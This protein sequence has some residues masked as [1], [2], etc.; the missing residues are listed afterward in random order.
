L[1]KP[2]EVASDIRPAT[3]AFSAVS[4]TLAVGNQTKLMINENTPA[5]G[6]FEQAKTCLNAIVRARSLGFLDRYSTRDVQAAVDYL[7]RTLAREDLATQSTAGLFSSTG[8]PERVIALAAL[9][10]AY[11]DDSPVAQANRTAAEDVFRFI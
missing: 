7:D 6:L 3:R 11:T 10:N 9:E 8:S 1:P 2:F 5:P 4:G